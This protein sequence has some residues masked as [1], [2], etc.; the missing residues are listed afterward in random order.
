MTERNE[1]ASGKATTL[2]AYLVEYRSAPRVFEL[3]QPLSY[4]HMLTMAQDLIAGA[5]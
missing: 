4:R 5:Y 3:M 2:Q 1:G